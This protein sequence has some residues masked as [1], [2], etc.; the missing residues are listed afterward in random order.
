MMIKSCQ[1]NNHHTRSGL[2]TWKTLEMYYSCYKYK[3][4]CKLIV[5]V[6][7]FAARKKKN[8]KQS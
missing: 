1:G 8:E 4:S 2:I 7:C 5:I 3:M 6:F